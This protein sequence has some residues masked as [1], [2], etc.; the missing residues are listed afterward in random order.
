MYGKEIKQGTWN[1]LFSQHTDQ[2]DAKIVTKKSAFVQVVINKY[3][4]YLATGLKTA[5]RGD[6]VISV[7]E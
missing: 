4:I 5:S 7:I 2:L 6:R 3:L 1:P